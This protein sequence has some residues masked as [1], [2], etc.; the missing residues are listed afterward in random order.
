MAGKL[1]FKPGK[2]GFFSG[3]NISLYKQQGSLVAVGFYTKRLVRQGS[4]WNSLNICVLLCSYFVNGLEQST[5]GRA[6]S[7]H[8]WVCVS[9]SLSVSSR[10]WKSY[11]V[12]YWSHTPSESTATDCGG[13]VVLGVVVLET[14]DNFSK[15]WFEVSSWGRVWECGW[16]E[17]YTYMWG[18][19]CMCKDVL[20]LVQQT[21]WTLF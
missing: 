15:L 4:F 2:V 1:T 7:V 20:L 19:L 17:A 3:T 13:L 8:Y 12:N 6:T 21:T 14:C 18:R 9:L 10:A 11:I 16:V 5:F